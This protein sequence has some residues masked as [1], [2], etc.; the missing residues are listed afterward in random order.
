MTEH[1]LGLGSLGLEYGRT[2]YWKVNEV[3]DAATPRSWEGDVWSFSI[4]DYVCGG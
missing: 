1:S 4:P 3:N 2:Y